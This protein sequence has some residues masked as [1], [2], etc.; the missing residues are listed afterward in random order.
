M[1]FE[2]YIIFG[3]LQNNYYCVASQG[4]REAIILCNGAWEEIQPATMMLN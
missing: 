1:Q 4:T 3:N 2:M